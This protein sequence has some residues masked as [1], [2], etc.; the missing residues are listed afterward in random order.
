[1][2]AR[3]PSWWPAITPP[4]ASVPAHLVTARGEQLGPLGRRQPAEHAPPQARVFGG[5][6]VGQTQPP[7]RASGTGHAP[8]QPHPTASYTGSPPPGAASQRHTAPELGVVPPSVGDGHHGLAEHLRHRG[9]R[10]VRPALR[11]LPPARLPLAQ[12]RQAA[13]HAP[14]CPPRARAGS[15]PAASTYPRNPS[16]P[17][18]LLR[19]L[20]WLEDQEGGPLSRPLRQPTHHDQAADHAADDEPDDREPSPPGAASPAR[21]GCRPPGPACR[22]RT[23][24]RRSGRTP[25]PGTANPPPPPAGPA[26]ATP[27]SSPSPSSRS[28]EPTGPR[29]APKPPT[30]AGPDSLSTACTGRSRA[31][32]SK[33]RT[34][35]TSD[36]RN[37]PC[38]NTSS[39]AT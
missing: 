30:T 25:P 29:P 27:R 18:R 19:A 3:D 26:D 15:R 39:I 36:T 33:S 12:H 4:P 37:A 38:G 9:A 14:R 23:A 24:S 7:H 13:G 35:S 16:G 11:H 34:A 20:E 28:S 10:A 17:N 22:P 2:H 32:F 21:G 5:H 1:M 31:D 6:R 8:P